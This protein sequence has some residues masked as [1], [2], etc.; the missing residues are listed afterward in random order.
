MTS[1]TEILDGRAPDRPLVAPLFATLAAEVEGLDRQAFLADAGKRARLLAELA[2]A[3]PVDVLIADS[4]SGWDARAAGLAVDSSAA[5]PPALGP[6]PAPPRFDP[7]HPAAATVLDVLRRLPAVV[8]GTALG[9]TV[10]GPATL[11]AAAGG[12]LEIED[13]ARQVLAVVQAVT[14]A[15]ASIVVVREDPA[16]DVEPERYVRAAAP[17]WGSLRFFRAAGVLHVRGEAGRA[18]S[19]VLA[20][21][22][23]Y[24][25]CFDRVASPALVE[26]T[27]A[28]AR[29]F[30]LIVPADPQAAGM[31]EH[32]PGTALLIHDE[33]LAG[34]I[35][36]RD[37]RSAVARMTAT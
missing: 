3:I 22:G 29:P 9:V 5:G 37:L 12:A 1:L 25:S 30:G 2:G 19:A 11:V 32:L 36:V 21:P 24:V 15:G 33:D 16:V 26:A 20:G 34:R 31:P 14:Q 17:V 27:V 10:T 4:G 8:P 13:G 7:A 23:P 18:W 35:A 6:G 28:A